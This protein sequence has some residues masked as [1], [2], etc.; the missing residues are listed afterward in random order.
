MEKNTLTELFDID[1]TITKKST[2]ISYLI[3]LIKKNYLPVSILKSVPL[4]VLNYKYGKMN[5]KHF[6]R[7]IPELLG[8]KREYLDDI[9]QENFVKY[10]KPS[11]YPGAVD[12]IKKLKDEGRRLIIASSSMEIILKPLADFLGIEE[13]IA[14]RFAFENN[15]CKGCFDGIPVFRNE[16][17]KLFL[18][19]AKENNIDIKKTSF[20]SDSIHDRPLM[21][22]VG[23][24]VPTNPDIRLRLLAKSRGWQILNFKGTSPGVYS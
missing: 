19:Y 4:V 23:N 5:E 21:E 20:Y 9:A 16:K 22:A 10:I 14:T 17:K 18:D 6:N 7:E 24:P 13:I 3:L 12:Y 11:I 8:V 1:H 2:A 15:E